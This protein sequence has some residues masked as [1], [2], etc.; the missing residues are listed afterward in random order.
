MLTLKTP[1]KSEML[2]KKWTFSKKTNKKNHFSSHQSCNQSPIH[3]WRTSRST[4]ET[5][6]FPFRCFL[7]LFAVC[8]L[9]W[10]QRCTLYLQISAGVMR[11]R[12]LQWISTVIPIATIM[13][14]TLTV[15]PFIVLSTTRWFCPTDDL[16]IYSVCLSLPIRIG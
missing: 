9:I 5:I 11:Q 8:S 4:N 3:T 7:S 15:N 14:V 2:T 6:L 10:L 1:K 12:T 13:V 16:F